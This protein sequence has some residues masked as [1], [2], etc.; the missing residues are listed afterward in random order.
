M[1]LSFLKVA[2]RNWGP[3][4]LGGLKDWTRTAF[5]KASLLS[6]EMWP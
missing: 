5:C 3:E 6:V 1:L 2:E 4:D